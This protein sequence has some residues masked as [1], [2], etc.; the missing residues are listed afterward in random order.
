MHRPNGLTPEPAPITKRL[1][2]AFA[3][4]AAHEGTTQARLARAVGVT[5]ASVNDWLQGRAVALKPA[6]LF[7]VADALGICPRWLAT[8]KGPIHNTESAG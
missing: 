6:H 2:A 7:A 4:A 5:R 8:G 3:V 1:R